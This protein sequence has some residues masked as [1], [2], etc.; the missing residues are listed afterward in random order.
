MLALGLVQRRLRFRRRPLAPFAISFADGLL[1]P[2][3]GLTAFLLLF[4]LGGGLSGILFADLGSGS[5]SI[6]AR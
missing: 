5:R 2:A 1:A 3:L 6:P 4:E